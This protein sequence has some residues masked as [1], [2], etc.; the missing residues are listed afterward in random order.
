MSISMLHVQDQTVLPS[1]NTVSTSILQVH[2]F[3]ACP[4]QCC[5]SMSIMYVYVPAAC[6]SCSIDLNIQHGLGDAAWIWTCNLGIDMHHGCGNPAWTYTLLTLTL[7]ANPNCGVRTSLALS[8]PWEGQLRQRH[9]TCRLPT[10]TQWWGGNSSL[11]ADGAAGRSA[12]SFTGLLS[13]SN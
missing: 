1:L 8:S 5:K 9:A 7:T 10:S 11:R 13:L 12:G 4:W 3:T 2:V 6:P